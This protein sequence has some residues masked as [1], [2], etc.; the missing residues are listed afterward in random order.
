M[1]LV[2]LGNCLHIF[3]TK[4]G[5]FVKLSKKNICSSISINDPGLSRREIIS[6]VLFY[7][8]VPKKKKVEKH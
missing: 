8:N 3:D 4:Q 1:K 2:Y 7:I 5:K 6:K